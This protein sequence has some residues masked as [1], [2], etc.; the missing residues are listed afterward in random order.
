MLL[1]RRRRGPL[2]RPNQGIVSNPGFETR[3][4][5]NREATLRDGNQQLVALHQR[6]SA[7][8]GEPAPYY[9]EP[10]ISG[11]AEGYVEIGSAPTHYA[12]PDAPPGDPAYDDFDAMDRTGTAREYDE[13][14]DAYNL[15]TGTGA[16]TCRYPRS[17][18]SG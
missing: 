12:E 3:Q 17:P 11:S 7:E 15:V 2:H 4:E 16:Q 10:V 9:E 13:P 1:R 5:L 8:L 18:A 6:R 14:D